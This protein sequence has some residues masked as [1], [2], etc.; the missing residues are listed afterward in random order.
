MQHNLLLADAVSEY[1]A[2][3]LGFV[4]FAWPWGEPGALEHET[5][6]DDNQR[7]FLES[8]GKEVRE[9][10]FDCSTPVMPIQMSEA[11]GHGTGKSPEGTWA[12]L[13]RARCGL[14]A[15]R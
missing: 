7:E 9:R 8:L 15:A 6:P 13:K 1:Y 2:D 3:P 4:M 10:G 14:L 12:L 5:G 11:S